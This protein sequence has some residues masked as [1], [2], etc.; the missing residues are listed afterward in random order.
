MSYLNDL[1]VDCLQF[2]RAFCGAE[3]PFNIDVPDFIGKLQQGR[4]NA[5][6]KTYQ[7]AVG[8]P[9]IVSS[10]C[11]EPCKLVCPLK[12]NGGAISLRLLEKAAMKYAR[13]TNP[14]QFNMPLKDKRIA[15]IGGGICGLACALRLSTRKYDVTIFE[16]SDKI[17]GHLY[18]VADSKIFL[19]DIELQFS[20]ESYSLVLNSE[21]NDLKELD[22]DAIFI[23]TGKGGSDFGLLRSNDGA[24]ATSAQG[25]FIGG[26]ITGANTMQAI[27]QGLE[28]SNAIERYLKIGKMNQPEAEKGTKLTLDAIRII[29]NDAILPANADLYSKEE[30]IAEAKR[31]L[32]CK[33]DACN[34]Y[35]PLLSYFDKFP[36]RVTEEVEITIVP[37]SLDGDASIATRLI[38]TC[39]QCGLCKEVCP[40]NIDVGKFLLE[41]HRTMREKD[42]MPWA[43]HE[44]FLRDMEFSNSDAALTKLP[45][46]YS[47]SS[48]FFFPGCQLGAS[49]PEYVLSSYRFLT[50]R[51][52]DTALMLNCCGAP[53]DW[54]GD[55]P[56]HNRTMQ[57]IKENWIS[58]GK[59]T[60]IFACPMCKKMFQDYLPEIKGIFLYDLIEEKDIT[61]NN[62]FK[63][64]AASVFD[65]CASRHEPEL[66]NSIRK[67]A[68]KV[69]FKL[70]PLP[71][72]GKM[73]ECCSYGGQVAIA[74]PPYA[75]YTAQKRIAQNDN[76]YITYC[77]NCR[78]IFTREG[79]QTWHILDVLFN[80]EQKSRETLPSI[81]QR[82]Y[83]RLLLR[84]QVLSEFWN[85]QFTIKNEDM[86]IQIPE[87]LKEKLSNEYILESDIQKVI[88]ECEQSGNKI[89]DPAKDIYTGYMQIGNMTIWA[90][91]RTTKEANYELINAYCHRMKIED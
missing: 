77:S 90:V 42:K 63:E 51:F 69:G 12:D 58:L 61:V 2:E 1:V 6:Y 5:A 10:L 79:K 57:Q 11:H 23:A 24:Y 44:F 89:Y 9:G 52:P 74:N 32:K 71:M 91:Y 78:D 86:V 75:R 48:Y 70:E 31:C 47:K 59:P 18:D 76:P 84:Q 88:A 41:S 65:P 87:K 3:C 50:S 81:S 7:H 29:P 67:M 46:G 49:D 4:F 20:F 82:R 25:V 14:D 34:H 66:Q 54:A 15:I 45:E 37:S 83:N 62:K 60:A 55:E 64:I 53:A 35:S 22:F 43:F 33:C 26:S 28:V 27:A 85:E 13:S 36:R 56:I 80:L 73:A 8:F 21:I 39:N 17:G 38:A 72:E 30:T 68:T 16:K 19:E 40:V